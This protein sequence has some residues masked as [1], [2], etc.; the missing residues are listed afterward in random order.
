MMKAAQFTKVGGPLEIVQVPIP[1]PGKGQI[2]IKVQACGICHGD[3]TVQY[4]QMGCKLPRIP[5]HEVV[6]VVHAL[7]EGVTEYKIGEKVGVGWFGGNCGHCKACK[8]DSWIS[9]EHGFAT[10][11]HVDGG[12]A[13]YMVA[14]TGALARIP[15][16]MT[17]E[18]AGPLLCAGM[19]TFN[20]LKH[21]GAKVGDVV[22]IS[23]VG[24]LGHLGVQY[25]AKMG[26]NVVAVSNGKDKEA[27]ARKLGAHHYFDSNDAKKMVEEINKLGGAK[28]VIATAP[29]A[30]PIDELIPALGIGGKVLVV[31][32]VLEPLKTPLVALLQK[33]QSIQ[34]W[35]SGDS[36]DGEKCI[37]FS[38]LTGVKPM[39]EVFPLDK[40]NDAYTHM[41][42]NKSRFRT[43]LKI[44][45]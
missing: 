7:G 24:G 36:R 13:E 39:I 44:S 30:K 37:E 43:V 2:R 5:G 38:A 9:C 34:A 29:S 28:V 8:E 4:A 33:R 40:A 23:G 11:V 45:D 22:V 20:V 25:A 31:G 21:S 6:G 18:E 14:S 27:L 15:N 42:S 10:G 26:F 1:N 12:Y 3:A 19:T 16:E 32:V 41:L 17:A 35:S